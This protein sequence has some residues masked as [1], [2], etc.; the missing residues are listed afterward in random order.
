[1]LVYATLAV[2]RQ[3]AESHTA[4]LL[5]GKEIYISFYTNRACNVVEAF[6]FSAMRLEYT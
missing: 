4:P 5:R 1:M 3:S 2:A 6:Y